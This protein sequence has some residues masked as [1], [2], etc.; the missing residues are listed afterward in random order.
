MEDLVC[1]NCGDS[2]EELFAKGLFNGNKDNEYYCIDCY[3][4]IH[5]EEF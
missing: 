3:E 5:E 1:P 4:E 2:F